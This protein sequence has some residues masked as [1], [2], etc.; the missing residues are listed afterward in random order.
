MVRLVDDDDVEKQPFGLFRPA[1]EVLRFHD[2][3]AHGAERAARLF[4]FE[5]ADIYIRADVQQRALAEPELIFEHVYPS[6]VY[7]FGHDQKERAHLVAHGELA[8]HHARLIR[9]TAADHVSQQPEAAQ[10]AQ[11]GERRL[12]LMPQNDAVVKALLFRYSVAAFPLFVLIGIDL[13]HGKIVVTIQRLDR[14]VHLRDLRVVSLF[15]RREARSLLFPVENAQPHFDAV[16]PFAHFL[17][18]LSR[19]PG[20]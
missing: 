8:Q 1:H 19:P 18:S 20:P 9:F 13:E 2:D 4:A 14:P 11:K 17:F 15:G 3:R 6:R 12:A 10:F 5:R 16:I 7:L